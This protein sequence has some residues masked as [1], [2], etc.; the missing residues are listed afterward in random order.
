MTCSIS[1]VCCQ[2]LSSLRSGWL[3]GAMPTKE[4]WKFTMVASGAQSVMTSG[5]M[6]MLK[7]S[8]GS[9]ALGLFFYMFVIPATKQKSYQTLR[10][11]WETRNCQKNAPLKSYRYFGAV[12]EFIYR[13]FRYSD[14]NFNSL[15]PVF[16]VIWEGQFCLFG[17]T[18]KECLRINVNF[19]V[20]THYNSCKVSIQT[21]R[22]RK[23][24]FDCLNLY[25]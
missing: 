1:C 25:N 5:M 24:I 8:V 16:S 6:Q 15:E 3:V 10:W 12:T 17:Q 9:S 13:R 19:V 20:K 23:E 2:A 11:S 7:L 22:W 18:D 21:C 4:E 14:I